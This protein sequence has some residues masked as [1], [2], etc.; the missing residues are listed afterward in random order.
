MR[1]SLL[2]AVFGL[3]L[4]SC[5][6]DS[7]ND[8]FDI[9]AV[10]G[11]ARNSFGF[12]VIAKSLDADDTYTLDFECDSITVGITVAGYGGGSAT[13]ELRDAAGGLILS[14]DLGRAIAEGA[15]AIA[16]D[17]AT[18]NLQFEDYSGIVS[19]GI[20]AKTQ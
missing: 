20:A 7:T 10:V 16:G 9:P 18:A 3:A 17:P 12:S 11:N 4:T 1:L 13:L 8:G 5:S 19:L 2:A 15:A 6:T 14:R